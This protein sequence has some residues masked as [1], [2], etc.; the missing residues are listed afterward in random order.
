[1]KNTHSTANLKNLRSLKYFQV[2]HLDHFDLK[3]EHFNWTSSQLELRTRNDAG[4]ADY[5]GID[6]DPYSSPIAERTA[7]RL[8]QAAAYVFNN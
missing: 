6:V 7:L 2:L 5:S 1:M 4:C 8:S 3:S